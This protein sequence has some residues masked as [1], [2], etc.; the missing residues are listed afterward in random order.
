MGMREGRN[1]GLLILEGEL[2]GINLGADYCAEHEWGIKGIKSKLGIDS[3]KLGLEQ[4]KMSRQ[5]S[6]LHW[7]EKFQLNKND[8]KDKSRWSGI[9][10]QHIYNGDE[11]YIRASAYG[12]DFLTL[13]CEDGFCALSSDPTKIEQLKTVHDAFSNNDIAIWLGG[14]GPFQNA[15]LCVAI[16]SKLPKEITD[17]WHEHDVEHNQLMAD[18]HATG[19]EE[20]LKK[21]G[22]SY[23]ALSPRREEDGSLVFWL[24]PMEQKIH[25]YGWFKLAELE[26]W[27]RNE[28]PILQSNKSKK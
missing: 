10:F 18:F 15:G 13:W 19:I 22:K 27:A 17:G 11:P 5:S 20:K 28:G 1:N 12:N 21:A 9:Y 16:A 26:A 2:V 25:N 3:S 24:N 4:R 7:L 8:K 14:G 23:F 6:D